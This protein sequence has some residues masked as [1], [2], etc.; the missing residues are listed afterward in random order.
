M[1][2]RCF[3]YPPIT[4]PFFWETLHTQ[5]VPSTHDRALSCLLPNLTTMTL[6][7]K[8]RLDFQPRDLSPC[9]VASP[10]FLNDYTMNVDPKTDTWQ[11]SGKPLVPTFD[12]T[13]VTNK[14]SPSVTKQ[15]KKVQFDV[16]AR[17]YEPTDPP[18]TKT[19]RLSMFYSTQELNIM[20]REN[21]RSVKEARRRRK[22]SSN[23]DDYCCLRG[24]EDCISIR[25]YLD[26]RS[27]K[28]A[29][30]QAVFD[31]Q[32]QQ[33]AEGICPL[34]HAAIRNV[35]RAASKEARNIA[36][37]LG[38]QD[39]KDAT[40]SS[41][42]TKSKSPAVSS[43]AQQVILEPRMRNDDSISWMRHN[44]RPSTTE[45]RIDTASKLFVLGSS[46]NSAPSS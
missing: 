37:K 45:L 20:Y 39:A 3:T 2:T 5:E 40:K 12:D 43:S 42:Q 17:M 32:R 41:Q 26:R 7:E 9:S 30:W 4:F 44:T 18:L 34:D 35:S 15:T 10:S 11:P 1:T 38:K 46:T 25:S 28:V 23:D 31:E 19:E 14:T 33:R 36:R 13:P 8:I 16:V 21:E 6:L 27:R 29:V 24:L 22:C